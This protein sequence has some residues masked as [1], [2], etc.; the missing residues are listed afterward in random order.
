MHFFG[1][2]F[3]RV[4]AVDRARIQLQRQ[5]NATCCHSRGRNLMQHHRHRQRQ[6]HRQLDSTANNNKLLTCCPPSSRWLYPLPL[7]SPVVAFIHHSK[8]KRNLRGRCRNALCAAFKQI[9]FIVSPFCFAASL[10][11]L[12]RV[13]L[14]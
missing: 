11:C 5:R 8:P 10:I 1:S 4:V 12:W 13:R 9:Y 14:L 6:R 2:K 7:P 3:V